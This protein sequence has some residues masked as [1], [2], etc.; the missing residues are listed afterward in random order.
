MHFNPEIN[1]GTLLAA[2]AIILTVLKMHTDN[3]KMLTD[4][5]VK[6]DTLWRFFLKHNGLVESKHDDGE[7]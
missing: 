6:V 3:T 5:R 1:L 2:A 7:L 4:I